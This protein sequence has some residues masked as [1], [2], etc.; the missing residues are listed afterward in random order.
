MA[1]RVKTVEFA[2]PSPSDP[3]GDYHLGVDLERG[4]GTPPV[5]AASL[6]PHAPSS[7]SSSSTPIVEMPPKS[8]SR[9]PPSSGSRG[10]RELRRM[11]AFNGLNEEEQRNNISL[12]YRADR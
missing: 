4:A 6:N 3:L 12:R 9:A 8:D 11:H 5:S 1:A 2:V 7:S 10:N